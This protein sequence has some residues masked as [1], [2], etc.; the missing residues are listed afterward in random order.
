M[1]G[2]RTDN[3][4]LQQLS[5][6]PIGRRMNTRIT[7]KDR[8]S[9]I[10]RMMTRSSSANSSTAESSDSIRLTEPPNLTHP[11]AP[12]EQKDGAE[13][14]RLPSRRNI[15][16]VCL[17]P[18]SI[19]STTALP[20]SK[21]RDTLIESVALS[22]QGTADFRPCSRE[23]TVSTVSGSSVSTTV[24]VTRGSETKTLKPETLRDETSTNSITQ[25]ILNR[26]RLQNSSVLGVDKSPVMLQPRP[27]DI[28]A[29]EKYRLLRL[30][31]TKLRDEKNELVS[32]LNRVKTDLARIS[33]RHKNEQLERQH[34]IL[35]LKN[36][37]SD[38]ELQYARNAKSCES[39]SHSSSGH[40]VNLF[41]WLDKIN[42]A[43]ERP[44]RSILLQYLRQSES[45]ISTLNSSL[46]AETLSLDGLTTELEERN[47]SDS[48]TI[49]HLEVRV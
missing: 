13:G 38:R 18:D 15:T 44:S 8:R 10:R 30:K 37:L 41:N 28:E 1:D 11:S 29:E 48:N 47:R 24:N 9:H 23:R 39:T 43:A 3:E 36:Q 49:H 27:L 31:N 19:N 17:A 21:T 35:S 4:D 40:L 5:T 46:K 2:R 26:S 12:N 34:E 42:N 14:R 20:N 32:L 25:Q 33:T 45:L 6:K 7:I 16:S 22:T